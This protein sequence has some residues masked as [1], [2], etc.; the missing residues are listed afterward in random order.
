MRSLRS[1]AFRG[2]VLLSLAYLT[3]PFLWLLGTSFM[4]EKEAQVGRWVPRAPT[5]ANYAAFLAPDPKTAE[6]G[7]ATARK[8][9]PG[10]GNSLVVAGWVTAV[11]LLIGSLAA[12]A[13]ARLPFRGSVG[14]LLFY[15]GS[16]SVPGVA[17][18]IPMY[19]MMQG[20]GLL[21]TRLAV[22]LAHVTFTLPFTIWLLKG[23]FQTVPVDL[24]RAARVDGCS[25][26]RALF[27]VFL[28]VTAPGLIAT[29]VFCFVSS[30]GEF[31]FALLF[32]T[33]MHSKTVPVLASEFIA[34][35]EIPIGLIAAGGVLSVLL[36]VALAF[37]FQRL[38]VQG[39]GGSVTG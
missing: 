13:L 12:Y 4:N 17:I 3:G 34:E 1:F 16:R 20:A 2:L 21:D 10:I 9:V 8:F 31:L 30:W 35:I 28:P 25:R 18:M 5:L 11:N 7:L 14:L 15:L 29:A 26:L 23:Y 22:I 36:P 33:T 6:L 37:L 38:I 19:L 24:E 39:I 32:T 27:R